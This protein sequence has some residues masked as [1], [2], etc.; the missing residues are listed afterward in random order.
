M[1]AWKALQV[2]CSKVKTGQAKGLHTQRARWGGL[3]GKRARACVPSKQQGSRQKPKRPEP[4][5]CESE[6]QPRMG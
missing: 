1:D 6:A 3:R 2:L 4:A 5:P